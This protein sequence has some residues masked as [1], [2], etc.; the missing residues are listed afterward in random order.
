MLCELHI[1]F[2][3]VH[4]QVQ[5]QV[6][7]GETGPHVVQRHPK[8]GFPQVVHPLL[9]NVKFHFLA[10]FRQLQNQV[11]GRIVFLFQNLLHP[12]NK[13]V[14][15]QLQRGDIHVDIELRQGLPD[16]PCM[17]QRHPQDVVSQFRIPRVAFQ[18][19]NE[20]ARRNLS[21]CRRFIPQQCFRT[22]HLL[23]GSINNRL[24]PQE[25]MAPVCQAVMMNRSEQ[26]GVLFPGAACRPAE[27]HFRAALFKAGFFRNILHGASYLIG[28]LQVRI[29]KLKRPGV[30]VQRNH[31]VSAH[32]AAGAGLPDLPEHFLRNA[33]VIARQHKDEV[34]CALG[35]NLAMILHRVQANVRCGTQHAVQ[36]FRSVQHLCPV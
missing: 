21:V 19:G 14:R 22:G 12:R 25:E 26:R 15:I 36:C 23:G 18:E 5:Q 11:I 24:Q 1:Q 28:I 29:R 9:Q 30:H 33:P 4:V 31:T 16:F 35:I 7:G 20:A 13:V 3:L 2:D 27:K 17:L 34:S 6:D 10:A 32:H 8:A